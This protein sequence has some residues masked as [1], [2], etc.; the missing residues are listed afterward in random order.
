VTQIGNRDASGSEIGMF[1]RCSQVVRRRS[2]KPLLAGST[3]A[4]ASKSES[5]KLGKCSKKI[6]LSNFAVSRLT[7]HKGVN[8]R[9]VEIAEVAQRQT[10]TGG[11]LDQ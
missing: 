9:G 3:P 11:E 2:A 6:A 7:V 8:R 10:K 1:G 5:R 4:T